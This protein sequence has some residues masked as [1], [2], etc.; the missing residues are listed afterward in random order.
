MLV[1]QDLRRVIMIPH[2]SL[3]RHYII[4]EGMSVVVLMSSLDVTY[5]THRIITTIP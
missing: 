4:A 3:R 5:Q 2:D 1:I